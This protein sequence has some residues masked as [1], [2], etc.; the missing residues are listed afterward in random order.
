VAGTIA[1]RQVRHRGTI[2]GSLAHGDPASDLPAVL[3][4]TEGSVVARSPG[5][6]RSI[7]AA[8]LF[9]DYL[10]TSLADDEIL[11]EVRFPADAGWGFSHQKF[12]RRRE[13][14]AMV[15][16]LRPGARERRRLRGRARRADQHGIGAPAGDG[17]GGRAARAAAR[18][19]AD[20][21]RRGAGARRDGAPGRPQRHAGLQA[22]T[23]L[24]CCASAR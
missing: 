17:R 15:G 5:G 4:A 12:N 1:D 9:E 22:A 2:G 7:A 14:W 19:R 10:T 6:E 21:R 13:D 20:R 8:D 24:A 11:T 16:G 18:C 3:L 23:S